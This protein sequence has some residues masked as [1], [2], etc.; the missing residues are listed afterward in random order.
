MHKHV[1][2]CMSVPC[3]CALLSL[4]LLLAHNQWYAPQKSVT[5]SANAN[6]S[7]KV[8][9]KINAFICT[10]KVNWGGEIVLRLLHLVIL[11]TN[12]I[13]YDSIMLCL[14][15]IMAKLFYDVT[16]TLLHNITVSHGR[17]AILSVTMAEHA[18]FRWFWGL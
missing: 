4:W 15:V 10:L 5:L 7:L 11:N 16:S 17:N 6:Q 14:R 1:H 2:V 18:C 13:L 3:A 8:N 9:K 12:K